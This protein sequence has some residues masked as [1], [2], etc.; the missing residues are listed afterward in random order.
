MFKLF[1][2]DRS[3]NWHFWFTDPDTGIRKQLSTRTSNRREAMRRASAYVNS[4]RNAVHDNSPRSLSDFRT[5]HTAPTLI[6]SSRSTSSP[7]L[8]SEFT[9]EYIAFIS[10]LLTPKSVSTIRD[11]L[12]QFAKHIGDKPLS[13]I[14][15]EEC[16]RFI[17]TAHRSA[18]SARKHYGHLRSAF[19]KAC[20][21]SH[22]ERNPFTMFKRPK[23]P[24][25]QTGCF[26]IEDVEAL[27]RAVP[28][29]RFATRRLRHMIILAFETGLRLGEIRHLT[30]DAVNVER[31]LLTVQNTESFTT[32][33]KRQRT[34]PLSN[35]ALRAIEIQ[36]SDV[37]AHANPLVRRSRI[38][39]PSNRGQ[40]L[41]E[42]A[43][44]NPLAEFCAALFPDERRLSFHSLRRGYGTRLSH[45]S[46]PIRLIQ[47]LLGHGSVSV[48][49]TYMH[50]DER[51][52]QSAFAALNAE[53]PDPSV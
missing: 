14:S 51:D 47:H 26:S 13:D 4:F 44:C 2:R 3:K 6:D 45:A 20:R 29:E 46:V 33:S 42:A 15:L 50:V 41:C 49:E 1:R 43:V 9:R 37:V 18:H 24:E 35:S 31:R 23:A 10:G 21:W 52:F 40:A 39:F 25:V 28:T 19:D 36:R 7:T 16:E 30:I 48:T 17:G 34:V 27:L 11:S 5:R 22:I 38:L 8:L 32:K 53:H 12:R